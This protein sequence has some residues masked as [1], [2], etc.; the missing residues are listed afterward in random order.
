MKSGMQ[1]MKLLFLT[2]YELEEVVEEIL[3]KEEFE[4]VTCQAGYS[5][6][7]NTDVLTVVRANSKEDVPISSFIKRLNEHYGV[8]ILNYDVYE[9][10]DFGEGFAFTTK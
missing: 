7:I 1:S 10:G 3:E 2:P 4:S 9:V 6:E 8:H 5:E